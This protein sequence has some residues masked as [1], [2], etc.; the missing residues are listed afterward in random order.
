MSL[1]RHHEINVSN[2]FSLKHLWTLVVWLFSPC[3]PS[4]RLFACLL[5]LNTLMQMR[6]FKPAPSK[7]SCR[8]V[9]SLWILVISLVKCTKMVIYAA[10]VWIRNEGT[11]KAL[12]SELQFIL[13]AYNYLK[14][15][16][17]KNAHECTQIH[18]HPHTDWQLS[19][20]QLQREKDRVCPPF[21]PTLVTVVHGE[22]CQLRLIKS[23][24]NWLHY[25]LI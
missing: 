6:W 3:A 16:P 22:C 14:C 2:I 23:M 17:G 1:A 15:H 19:W 11:E 9:P 13:C 4:V 10:T 7:E 12:L 18:T 8:S 21:I 5:S 24:H 25:L 20:E